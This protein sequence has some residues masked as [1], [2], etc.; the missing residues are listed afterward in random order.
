MNQIGLTGFPTAMLNRV[1][2]WSYPENSNIQQVKI[3][4]EIMLV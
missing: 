2:T 3:K 4:L 1:T